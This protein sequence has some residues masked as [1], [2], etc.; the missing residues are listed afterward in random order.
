M[1][2]DA[3]NHVGRFARLSCQICC[4]GLLASCTT[5]EESGLPGSAA[6][7]AKD[8]IMLVR[9]DPAT[10]GYYRL[11]SQM[12]IHPDFDYFIK[13]R[14]TPDFLAETSDRY[15]S[16]FILY[17]LKERRA[18]ACRTR[19]ANPETM[20][21]SGPYPITRQEMATLRDMRGE[22]ADSPPPIR[23]F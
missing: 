11:T 7:M 8:Q 20:E 17:Y 16:Y 1:K 9:A 6:S 4:A 21:F 14:G 12:R 13:K 2:L 5:F 15:R 3:F 18:Y 19:I 22:G 10:L 23:F